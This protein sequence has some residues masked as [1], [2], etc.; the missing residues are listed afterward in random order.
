MSPRSTQKRKRLATTGLDS[1]AI[2]STRTRVLDVIQLRKCFI[3]Q[4]WSVSSD[5]G[6]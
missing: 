5:F 6:P 1:K 3:N 2:P 4:K